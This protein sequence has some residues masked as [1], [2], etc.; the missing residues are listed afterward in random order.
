M[1]DRGL[2]SE[3]CSP[4]LLVLCWKRTWF[5]WDKG[6]SIH[7]PPN[8][9]PHTIFM[10]V[11]P[12]T[13]QPGHCKMV[14]KTDFGFILFFRFNERK[15]GCKMWPYFLHSFPRNLQFLPAMFPRSAGGAFPGFYSLPLDKRDK[16]GSC[17]QKCSEKDF[18]R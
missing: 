7:L 18:S 14:W 4:F 13:V 1:V 12:R 2:C 6:Q 11:A 17:S 16:Q 5:L 8:N 3:I 15:F 9:Q 10:C